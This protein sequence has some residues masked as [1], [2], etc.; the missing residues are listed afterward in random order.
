MRAFRK[1]SG[2]TQGEFAQ[3]M[4]I[5]RNYVSMLENGEKTPSEQLRKHFDAL[6]HARTQSVAE[7]P[8][9]EYTAES[10]PEMLR[11]APTP[12][13][14]SVPPCLRSYSDRELLDYLNRIW[15]RIE[16]EEHPITKLGLLH[17]AEACV[18]ALRTRWERLP[19]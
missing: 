4:G 10:S 9:H 18:Q 12:P 2:L 5:S 7:T 3:Q 8:P 13:S 19:P 6:H 16:N 11:R 15:R 17:S 1:Q 14:A